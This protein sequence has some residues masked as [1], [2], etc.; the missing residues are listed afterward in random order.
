MFTVPTIAAPAA[1]VPLIVVAGAG[2]GTVPVA[3][4]VAVAVSELLQAVINS[5]KKN[6][7]NPTTQTLPHL[8]PSPFFIF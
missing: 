7:M 6:Y 1:A 8:F 2:S 3:V 5:S 4:S